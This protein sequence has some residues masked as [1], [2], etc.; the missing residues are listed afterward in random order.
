MQR[1]LVLRTHRRTVF[2]SDGLPSAINFLSDMI[3]YEDFRQDCQV[4]WLLYVQPV[5]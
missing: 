5:V 3:S 1:V 4:V 2:T